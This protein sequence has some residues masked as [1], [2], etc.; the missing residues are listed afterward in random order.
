MYREP[1]S[2]VEAPRLH[3]LESEGDTV[4]SQREVLGK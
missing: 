1:F 4:S 2:M 3:L